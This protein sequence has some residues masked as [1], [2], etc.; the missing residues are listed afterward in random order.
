[1]LFPTAFNR[2]GR[3]VQIGEKIELFSTTWRLFEG[4]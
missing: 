3:R 4:V 2:L 1:M